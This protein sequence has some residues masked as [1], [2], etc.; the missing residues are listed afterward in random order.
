[1]CRLALLNNTGIKYIEQ[2][3]GLLNFLDYLETSLGGHGNGYCII[4]NNNKRI[5]KKGVTLNNETIIKDIK[6][7][8]NH[9]KWLMYHTRLASIGTINNSNCHPF[10]DNQGNVL[11]MNGTEHGIKNFIKDNKTDT[12]TIINIC[13]N[14]NISLIQA[15]KNLTSVFIGCY[16]KQVFVN[17]N[18]GSLKFLTNTN[19]EIIF[20]SDFPATMYNHNEIYIAPESWIEGEKIN[21]EILK[22]DEYYKIKNKSYTKYKN[23]KFSEWDF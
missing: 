8:I 11:M 18:N 5:I 20:A 12:E 1:M 3:I 7:N 15:T 6:N 4:L 2:T 21:I 22:K 14:L 13:D 23:Y 10:R 19:N 9:I 17:K 16:K